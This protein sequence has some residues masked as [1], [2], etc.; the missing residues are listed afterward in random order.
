M[1]GDNKRTI[2]EVARLRPLREKRWPG[3]KKS[4]SPFPCRS[5]LRRSP[6]DRRL[7]RL[8]VFFELKLKA[9][10]DGCLANVASTQSVL[11]LTDQLSVSGSLFCPK[12]AK[13]RANHRTK[14][15]SW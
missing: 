9:T 6:I 11:T 5:V 13:D 3:Y 15:V 14:K 12:I 8:I 2:L 1:G 7:A 10:R 4:G